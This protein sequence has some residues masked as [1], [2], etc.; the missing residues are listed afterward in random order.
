MGH[1]INSFKISPLDEGKLV[2][3][4]CSVAG[5]RPAPKVSWYLNNEPISS[6]T[7]APFFSTSK[8]VQYGTTRPHFTPSSTTL[9]MDVHVEKIEL[10]PLNRFHQDAR[11]TCS[12][13]NSLKNEPVS[14]TITLEITRKLPTPTFSTKI[15]SSLLASSLGNSIAVSFA[16]TQISLLW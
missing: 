7:V 12:A 3:M 11:L 16:F 1:P 15:W 8:I 14:K 6:T 9:N 2:V 13:S 4:R 10:G 5:G